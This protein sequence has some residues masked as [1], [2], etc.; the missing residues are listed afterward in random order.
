M[1]RVLVVEDSPTV[2][3]LLVAILESDP[4]IQVIGTAANGEE[5][6]RRAITLK[7]DLITM[8]IKMP[9]MDGLEATRQIMATCPTPIVIVTGSSES[10]T[11]PITFNAM[12]AGA[13]DV[14]QK[15]VG[16]R[17]ENFKSIHK[18]LVTAVKLLA[19]V[20]VFRRDATPPGN[21]PGSAGGNFRVR[22]RA[23]SKQRGFTIVAIGA[24]TGGPAALQSLL[25]ALPSHFPLPVVVAQHMSPGFT[26]GLVRWLQMTS[27]LRLKMAQDAERL[28][29]GTVYFAPD[30]HHLLL[31]DRLTLGLSQAAPVKHVRPSVNVLFESV[32]RT[33]GATAVGVLLTGMG[34]DG[35]AGLKAIH[36]RGGLTLVQDEATSVV[37]G[38]PR[39]AVELGAADQILPLDE[40]APA[41]LRLLDP[42]RPPH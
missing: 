8:D 42:H 31:R 32:A 37:Y 38:M 34:D 26:K 11:L 19:G 35:A 40:M 9:V 15:P 21:S 27:E 17:H 6:V 33:H 20:K 25:K 30:Q 12:R 16:L 14:I 41:L 18:R 3:R 39:A 24:S 29:P 7:P 22:S 10:S 1:I 2:Q 5:A 13:L 36:D 28:L 4:E 23:S